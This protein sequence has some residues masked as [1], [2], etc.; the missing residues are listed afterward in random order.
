MKNNGGMRTPAHGADW[1]WAQ[2]QDHYPLPHTAICYSAIPATPDSAMDYKYINSSL[3]CTSVV[4]KSTR[5]WPSQPELNF[6]ILYA[7]CLML[8]DTMTSS[9]LIYPTSTTLLLH[10][11]PLHQIETNKEWEGTAHK[12]RPHRLSDLL[13]LSHYYIWNSAS[14]L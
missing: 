2:P 9:Y 14:I 5:T 8:Y 3:V 11:P 12:L 1:S 6:N 4:R 10:L 13:P 7:L